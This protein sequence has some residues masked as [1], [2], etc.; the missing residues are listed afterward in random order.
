MNLTFDI[1]KIEVTE[2]GVGRQLAPIES[3]L[4]CLPI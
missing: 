1:E 3:L 2:F 4:P